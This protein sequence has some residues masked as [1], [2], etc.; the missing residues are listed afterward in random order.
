MRHMR[1]TGGSLCVLAS[2][3]N[4]ISDATRLIFGDVDCPDCLRRAITECEERIRVLREQLV[5]VEALS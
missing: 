5:K 1:T 3:A 4:L 2:P